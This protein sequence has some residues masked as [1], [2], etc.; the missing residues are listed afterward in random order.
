MDFA[1]Q[2]VILLESEVGCRPTVY[3]VYMHPQVIHQI[4]VRYVMRKLLSCFR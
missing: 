2:A 1:Q 4:P 3:P